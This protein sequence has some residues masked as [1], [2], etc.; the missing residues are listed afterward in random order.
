MTRRTTGSASKNG[1]TGPTNLTAERIKTLLRWLS[2]SRIQVTAKEAVS[3]YL[4]NH[5]DLIEATRA[6][7]RSIARVLTAP[8]ECELHLG[9]DHDLGYQYICLTIRL[10]KYGDD[11]LDL[12]DQVQEAAD[13]H[14]TPGESRFL[15]TSDFRSLANNGIK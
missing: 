12:L 10:E 5:P 4:L 13:K 14:A 7:V 2:R 8:H 1:A 6:A 3:A 9:R 11:L 15:V